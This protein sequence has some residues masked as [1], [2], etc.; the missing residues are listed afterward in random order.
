MRGGRIAKAVAN[1]HEEA[2]LATNK[3]SMLKEAKDVLRRVGEQWVE[4][5]DDVELKSHE[6]SQ[7]DERMRGRRTHRDD[8]TYN[9]TVDS[10]Q[11]EPNPKF[12]RPVFKQFLDDFHPKFD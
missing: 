2:G 1:M 4:K 11:P 12:T 6:G 9:Q 10:P 8:E 5:D 3:E 7:F